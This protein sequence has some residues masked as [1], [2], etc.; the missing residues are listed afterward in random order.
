MAVGDDP[1]HVIVLCR[2]HGERIGARVDPG[3][4]GVVEDGGEPL[5]EVGADVGGVEKDRPVTERLPVGSG[6]DIPRRQFGVGVDVGHVAAPLV[7]DEDGTLAPQR[8]GEERHR[9]VIRRQRRG[10]ELHEFGIADLRPDSCRHGETVAG[11]LSR[12]RR[13]AVDPPDASG[14]EHHGLGEDRCM[15]TVLVDA[16]DTDN[17]LVLHDQVDHE[18]VVEHRDVGASPGRPHQCAH[19]LGTGRIAVGVDDAASAVARLTSEAELARSVGVEV[20][21]ETQ[22]PLDALRRAAGHDLRHGSISE[23][24]GHLQR[25]GG[26]Q[27]RPVVIGDGGCDTSLRPAAGSGAEHRLGDDGA[28]A[29]HESRGEPGDP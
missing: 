9:I 23:T 24:T 18:E 20:G 16:V 28:V 10:V 14:G 6:D 5:G 22:E 8:L 13:M 27:C 7:V 17:S 3:H 19:Q 25:V 1:T 12:V 29:G 4:R 15:G 21:A 2:G 11:D 26:M